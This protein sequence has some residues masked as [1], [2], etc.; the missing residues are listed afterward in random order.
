VAT[1]G[2]GAVRG[3]QSIQD[4]GQAGSQHAG[5][6]LIR[7]VLAA[8]LGGDGGAH[9]ARLSVRYSGVTRSLLMTWRLCL[10]KGWVN[11][12]LLIS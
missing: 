12:A 8:G 1:S 10:A 2:A 7:R 6:V 3:A 9:Q 5:P 4:D 11:H